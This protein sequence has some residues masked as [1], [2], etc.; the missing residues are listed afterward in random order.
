MI[1][2]HRKREIHLPHTA[3]HPF[4]VPGDTGLFV[5]LLVYSPPKQDLLKLWSEVSGVPSEVRETAVEEADKAALGVLGERRRR[6][7]GR[8]RSL[9]GGRSWCYRQM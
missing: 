1:L 7:R 5:D 6:A 4:I 2:E 8:V 9:G 3:I